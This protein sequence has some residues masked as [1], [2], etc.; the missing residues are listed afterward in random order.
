MENVLDATNMNRLDSRSV[1]PTDMENYLE[2]NGWHFN[3]KMCQWASSRMYKKQ[4]DQKEFIQPYT[5]EDLEALC[6]NYGIRFELNYDAVYIANMCKA[7][8]LGS[9]VFDE[10]HLVLYVKDVIE[11]PDAYDGM[12]F[13]RFYADCIGSGVGIEWSDMI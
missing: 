13:T 10:Q 12:P 2:F 7:D 9:S 1:Y 8:F 4:G 5:K 3:K 11:D 6:N